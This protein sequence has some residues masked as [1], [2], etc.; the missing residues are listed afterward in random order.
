MM[1]RWLKVVQVNDEDHRWRF[2]LKRMNGVDYHD[3]WIFDPKK[4]VV[5]DDVD[6]VGGVDGVDEVDDDD[7]DEG[8]VEV[9]KKNRL[10]NRLNCQPF[11]NH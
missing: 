1:I 11:V 3:R 2:D 7:N 4:M 6:G 5:Y 9:G 10:K 8:E